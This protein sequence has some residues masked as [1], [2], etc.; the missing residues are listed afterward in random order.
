MPSHQAGVKA[1]TRNRRRKS[2][3]RSKDL[4]IV[5]SPRLADHQAVSARSRNLSND[6][7]SCRRS[8]P[9]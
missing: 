7:M 1:R 4:V 2:P 3:G 5:V 6:S 9:T 8:R